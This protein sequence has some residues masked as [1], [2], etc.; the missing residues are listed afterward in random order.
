[1]PD[2]DMKFDLEFAS[3][4]LT[5]FA[6]DYITVGLKYASNPAGIPLDVTDRVARGIDNTLKAGLMLLSEIGRI[7][8]ILEQQRQIHIPMPSATP[9]I[10]VVC[11]ACSLDGTP[12]PWQCG[13][14]KFADTLLADRKPGV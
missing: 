12:V 5:Q 4:A 1:M 14:W 11:Q 7:R 3:T 13:V 10:P 2:T 8:T 6:V 9:G